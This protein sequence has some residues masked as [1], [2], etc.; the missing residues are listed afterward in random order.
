MDGLNLKEKINPVE[1]ST[2]EFEILK[3]YANRE[4]M[5]K[6][7]VELGV[8]EDEIEQLEPWG[9]SWH[10]NFEGSNGEP[11]NW[12]CITNYLVTLSGDRKVYLS[13]YAFAH[14]CTI[15]PDKETM[16]SLDM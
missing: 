11:S 2:K 12:V 14:F 13:P 3:K 4:T 8:N 1:K 16:T 7:L 6:Q 9:Q 10:Q 5:Q 15:S